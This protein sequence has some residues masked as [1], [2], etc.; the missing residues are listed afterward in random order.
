MQEPLRSKT[1][2]PSEFALF[3]K[4]PGGE[5]MLLNRETELYC[6]LNPVGAAMW[7]ALIR[8]ESTDEAV[9][10]LQD[11][12]DVDTD[13]L[14]RDLSELIAELDARGLVEITDG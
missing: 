9:D 3:E 7:S 2:R 8:C 1:V 10:L 11:E 13:T 5:A 14:W 12:Y 4:L 6:S